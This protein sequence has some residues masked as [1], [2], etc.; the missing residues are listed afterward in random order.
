[1]KP[2]DH[3]LVPQ[4][5]YSPLPDTLRVLPG[6]LQHMLRN[7]NFGIML[8]GNFHTEIF[9]RIFFAPSFDP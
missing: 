7:V 8:V 6:A 3:S 2:T 1:M 4:P 5:I 9:S